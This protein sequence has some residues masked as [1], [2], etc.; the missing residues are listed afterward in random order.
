MSSGIKRILLITLKDANSG[1]NKYRMLDPHIKLQNLYP[2][3][4]FIEIGEDIDILNTEK[5]K[6]FDA[7]FYHVAI[8][9]AEQFSTQTQMLKD[10]KIVKLIMDVDDWWEY[11]PSHP[12]Y[13]MSKQINLKEKTIK[14]LRKADYITTTTEHFAK[15]IKTFNK[16]VFIIPNCINFKE[17]Q[18]QLTKHENSEL[19]NI[20]YVAG[21]SH[22]EDIKLLR[23]VLTSLEKKPTQMQLCGFNVRKDKELNSTWH[24]MEV[25]FTDNYNLKDK[26]YVD[27]LM[28][29]KFDPF[30][31]EPYMEY[32]RVWTQPI[33][34]YMTMYDELDLCLAPLKN[35]EFNSYKSNLKLL[36]AGAKKKPIIVSG[37][38][39]YLDGEHLK[40][41]LIV[42]AKKEHK[43]WIKYVNQMV[44]N[45]QMRLD[46]G[47]NLYEYVLNNFDLEKITEKRAEFYNKFFENSKI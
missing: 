20:G 22:L 6:Q 24:K 38:T 19:L 8:E 12:Y 37:V 27:Y 16:N 11:H 9:Q 25:E 32:K 36:E 5:V 46:F 3:D 26:L 15:K 2:K 29:F 14:A 45:S 39:P 42:D 44:D 47:E 41:C 13:K 17:K 34:T 31:R 33:N 7:V 40:N 35:Y 1:I 10:K 43:L 4:Y 21:V 30:P 23:G 28:E 18:F